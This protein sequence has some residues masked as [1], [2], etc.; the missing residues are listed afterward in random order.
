MKVYIV[1]DVKNISFCYYNISINLFVGDAMKLIYFYLWRCYDVDFNLGINLSENTF[2]TLKKDNT[3]EIKELEHQAPLNFYGENIINVSAIVGKNGSGKS[4]ILNILGL[5]RLD[6]QS[7]YPDS[8]WMAIYENNGAYFLEGFN[9]EEKF[10][11]H[12]Y[13]KKYIA[14]SLKKDNNE[15]YFDDFIQNN[16][17]IQ[18]NYCI[19]HNPDFSNN[20]N[21]YGNSNIH[22]YDSRNY[23]FKRSYL[24]TNVA[25]LYEFITKNNDFCS[26]LNK[27]NININI[28]DTNKDSTEIKFYSQL[29]YYLEHDSLIFIRSK[30]NIKKIERNEDLFIISLIESYITYIINNIIDEENITNCKKIITNNEYDDDMLNFTLIKESLMKTTIEIIKYLE[31][32]HDYLFEHLNI[33]LFFEIISLI[34]NNNKLTF[35]NGQSSGKNKISCSIPLNEYDNSIHELILKIEEINAP[36]AI[37]IPNMSSGEYSLNSKIAGI[38]KAINLSENEIDNI[39]NFIIILDEYDEN[40]HPEWSRRFFAYLLDYLKKEHS[41]CKFQLIISTHS[42]YIISDLMKENVIKIEYNSLLKTFYS[43]KATH[44]FASN[45]YDIINDSFFLSQPIGKFAEN[46]INDILNLI[47]DKSINS[48]KYNE[49][50]RLINTIDDT[51]IRKTLLTKLCDNHNFNKEL[52][53]EKIEDDIQT[54]ISKKNKLLNEIN[55]KHHD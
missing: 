42:P 40:L 7:C 25:S 13:A 14:Y 44:S 2:I 8:Q 22:E 49:L 17:N 3:L 28:I 50:Q 21:S 45:V 53:L 30:K 26:N 41:E 35:N 5:N 20:K 55:G 19:I 29:N 36:I 48:K 10:N 12:K 52:Q 23:G 6:V 4:T 51:Y 46:K 39:K 9:L 27:K 54:L 38:S 24:K 47:D 33:Q 32:N 31:N 11:I 43:T 34:K 37:R 1:Y 18:N 16:G 15:L